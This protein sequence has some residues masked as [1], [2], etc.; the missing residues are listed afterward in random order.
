MDGE[1][2]EGMYGG[3]GPRPVCCQLTWQACV[4]S[5]A[6][7]HC[8]TSPLRACPH[9]PRALTRGSLVCSA[10]SLPVCHVQPRLRSHSQSH[11]RASTRPSMAAVLPRSWPGQAWWPALPPVPSAALCRHCSAP[12]HVRTE[13]GGGHRPAARQRG[14]ADPSSRGGHALK[15]PPPGPGPLSAWCPPVSD[16]LGASEPSPPA[17]SPPVW[18]PW[19]QICS[20]YRFATCLSTC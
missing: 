18:G 11:C 3:R 16:F 10:F 9:S 8:N 6:A 19:V 20:L 5:V 1:W 12:G 7:P 15:G 17:M 13:R 2:R 4:P 14:L